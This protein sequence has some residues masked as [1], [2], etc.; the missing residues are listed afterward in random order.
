[1]FNILLKHDIL[2]VPWLG[3]E[4]VCFEQEEPVLPFPTST[5]AN[6][7]AQL[8][9]LHT[10]EPGEDCPSLAYTKGFMHHPCIHSPTKSIPSSF[11]SQFFFPGF[12]RKAAQSQWGGYPE[13]DGVAF[14]S[15]GLQ[16]ACGPSH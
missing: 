2:H 15:Q 3:R 7:L 16:S 4:N 10:L 13:S 9:P 12:E 6:S 5:L 14:I 1:M 11:A 8:Y